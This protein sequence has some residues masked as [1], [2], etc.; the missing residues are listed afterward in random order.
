MFPEDRELGFG[1]TIKTV[2]AEQTMPVWPT[3]KRVKNTTR[4]KIGIEN[5]KQLFM[6]YGKLFFRDFFLR[7]KIYSA[8]Q[9]WTYLS[10]FWKHH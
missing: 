2:Q 8:F 6:L 4:T 10:L 5:I 9:A 3:R 1:D 7:F